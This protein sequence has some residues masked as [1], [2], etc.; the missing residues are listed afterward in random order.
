MEGLDVN[1]SQRETRYQSSFSSSFH[2]RQAY[3]TSKSTFPLE[4]LTQGDHSPENR[5]NRTK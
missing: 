1:T 4:R 2:T 5:K 3:T